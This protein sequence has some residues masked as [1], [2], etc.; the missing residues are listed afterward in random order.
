[1]LPFLCAKLPTEARSGH[2]STEMAQLSF[3]GAICNCP[4]HRRASG[5]SSKS[6]ELS[7]SEGMSWSFLEGFIIHSILERFICFWKTSPRSA[8][9]SL[10]RH[11]SFPF[12]PFKQIDSI[13]IAKIIMESVAIYRLTSFII[14]II[15]AAKHS[16][17]RRPGSRWVNVT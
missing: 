7:T 3:C 17:A 12:P 16:R 4:N 11:L 13:S 10:S 5:F 6:L 15:S 1:M 9:G 2:D 14:R 8:C